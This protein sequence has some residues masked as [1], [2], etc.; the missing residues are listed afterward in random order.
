M[1]IMN[2]KDRYIFPSIFTQE[3]DGISIEFPDLKG[4][5]PCGSDLEE[6]LINAKEAMALHIYSMEKDNEI[7]PTQTEIKDIKTNENQA[8]FF[9]DVW[10]PTFREAI[11]NK[12]IKKTLTIPKWLD[13]LATQEKVNFSQV[14]QRALKDHL[15]IKDK[16]V[17]HFG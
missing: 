9:I 16:D 4:C 13:D 10:M 17:N 3:D 12:A 8:I 5:L 15:G 2:K 14:L 11:E 6:S 7:I 1:K